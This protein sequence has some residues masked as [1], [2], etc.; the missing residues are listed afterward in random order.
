MD[1][2]IVKNLGLQDYLYTYDMMHQ[3]TQ[4]RHQ[5]TADEIWLVEHPAVYTQGKVGKAEHLLQQTTIPVIQTDRGGQITYH[6][7]GQQIMYILLDLKRL[8]I[9]IRDTVTFLENSVIRTLADYQVLAATQANAPG[10]YVNGKKICSLGLHI[11]HGCTL[12]GL[13]LNVDLDLTPFNYINPCGYQGL[14]MTRLND[15][16]EN[17]NHN[18]VRQLLAQYFIAQLPLTP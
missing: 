6:A 8:K 11:N 9:G 18:E 14:Q 7:P 5:S 15:Y 17:I 3:F 10:V 2:P 1:K 16:V 4:S 12:H 13:A